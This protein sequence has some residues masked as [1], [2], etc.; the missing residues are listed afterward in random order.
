[1]IIQCKECGTKYEFDKSQIE[2]EGVWVRCSHCEATFFQKNPLAEISSLMHLMEPEREDQREVTE[3]NASAL[4]AAETGD[5]VPGSTWEEAYQDAGEDIVIE[6]VE[7]EEE[8]RVAEGT[9]AGDAVQAPTWEDVS[10]DAGDDI[11]IE[12]VTED[13]GDGQKVLGEIEVESFEPES[14]GGDVSPDIGE[15]IEIERV[16]EEE[17]AR[18]AEGTEAGDAVPGPAWEDVSLEAGE[19]IEIEGVEE[20]AGDSQKV[21]EEIEVESREPGPTGEATYGDVDEI[22]GSEETRER[23]RVREPWAFGNPDEG[24]YNERI[25][26]KKRGW[27]LW[28]FIKQAVLYLVLLALLSGGVYLWLVPEARE[29]ISNRVSPLV[30]KVLRIKDSGRIEGIKKAVLPKVEKMLEI[31]GKS[32]PDKGLPELKVTMVNVGERFVKGLTD[33]NIMVV[34]GSAVNANTIAVSNIRVRGKILDS[35]GNILSEEESNCGAI[36]TDDELKNLTSDEIKKELSNPYGRD[37]SN[38]D[39][40]PGDGIP[41]M[42]VFTIPAEEASELVVELVSIEAA[43]RE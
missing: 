17:E 36:L 20:N 33:E 9:E 2:G 28:T 43:K 13:S 29:R 23:Q 8:A 27:G 1:M 15:G 38:A 39:I 11:E 6:R 35:S 14:T 22:T 25:T 5:A 42:L 18:V 34:E 16:E 7:E 12:G 37:F 40:K 4:G 41:F 30:E 21:L 19:G 26:G 31:K 10:L 3:E 24:V 32:V